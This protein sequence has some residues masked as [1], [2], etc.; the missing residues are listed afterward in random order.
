VRVYVDSSALLKRAFQEPESDVLEETL[1]RHVEAADAL[2]SSSLAWVEV[3]RA[4]RRCLDGEDPDVVNGAS[5]DALAGIAERP[6]TADV[7]SLARR[8]GPNLLRSLNAIHLATAVM[9][10]ADILITYDDRLAAATSINGMAVSS[11]AETPDTGSGP[12]KALSCQ[13]RRPELRRSRLR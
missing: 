7:I 4:L 5:E 1:Q 3:S 10:D 9:I 13:R 2:V 11:P 12:G 6:I 8:V